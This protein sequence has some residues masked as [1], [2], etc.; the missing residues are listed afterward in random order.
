[1]LLQHGLVLPTPV[2]LSLLLFLLF[3]INQQHWIFFHPWK[4]STCH[5]PGLYL[6]WF[7][8]FCTTCFFPTFGPQLK[9]HLL[10]IL[11]K[12]VTLPSYKS[13]TLFHYFFF[14]CFTFWIFGGGV[15]GDVSHCLTIFPY[16]MTSIFIPNGTNGRTGQLNQHNCW[17][18]RIMNK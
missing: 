9:C 13:H 7:P 17:N 18:K 15:G 6:I 8:D 10:N 5:G 16:R 11:A 12:T 2:C 14:S 4:N 3:I 1:M